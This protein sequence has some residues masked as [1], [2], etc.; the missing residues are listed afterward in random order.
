M[1]D[2]A[3][4]ISKLKGVAEI[5]YTSWYKENKTEKDRSMYI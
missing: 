3:T 5:T 1:V 2:V 4:H